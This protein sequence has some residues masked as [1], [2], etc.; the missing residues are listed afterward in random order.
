MAYRVE[1]HRAA[2]K[3]FLSFRRGAQVE[4]AKAIDELENNARPAG[5]R[6]LRETGLWRIRTG[7]YRIVYVIDDEAKVVTVVKV[8]IRREDTYKG[9]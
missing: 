3:Q 1:I 7:R 8:A 9:L 4:I 5:C 6:K 2:Q